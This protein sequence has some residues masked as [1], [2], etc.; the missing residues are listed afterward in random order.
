MANSDILNRFFTQSLFKNLIRFNKHPVYSRIL[1]YLNIS[2]PN[3]EANYTNIQQIY[4]YMSKNYRNEYIYKNTIVNKLLI[5]V[6]STNTTVAI[7]EVP[8][9]KSKA[10]IVLI[11]GKA[12]VFEIKT[13]LDNFSR[14]DSQINDYFKAFTRVCVVSTLNNFDQLNKLY[15]NSPVGIY[16]LNEKNQIS[17]K[18]RKEPT[19]NTNFLEYKSIFKLLHKQEY[20]NLIN[21]VYGFIP[22]VPPAQLYKECFKLFCKIPILH[23][24]RNTL[25]EIKKRKKINHDMLK[26][27]P[28]ELKSLVYFSRYSTVDCSRLFS[29]LENKY[30]EA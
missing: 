24:Y 7:S 23:A 29:F 1:G 3:S 16:I 26:T 2:M 27:V 4:S 6:H 8:I 9:N 18:F 10:D 30:K 11:N 21:D 13:D 5:G 12:T 15:E 22:V 17:K 28:Y 20:C 25:K 19:E 14:L